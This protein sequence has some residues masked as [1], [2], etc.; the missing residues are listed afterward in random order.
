[1]YTATPTFKSVT[2]QPYD[3]NATVGDDVVFRC[4]AYAIPQASVIW[5]KN[6]EQITGKSLTSGLF[7][8]VGIVMIDLS[9]CLSVTLWYCIS[10]NEQSGV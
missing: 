7:I 1:M 6:G 9:V 4:A 5:Y 2:D 10:H 3:Y 8:S